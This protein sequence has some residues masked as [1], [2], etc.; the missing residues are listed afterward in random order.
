VSSATVNASPASTLLLGRAL[1]AP[2]N[3]GTRV[4]GR[5]LARATSSVRSVRLLSL[6]REQHLDGAATEDGLQL[7]H[8]PSRVGYGAAGD[9][10]GMRS[11]LGRLE[12][13]Q[14]RERISTAHLLSLP[15][16]L[17][18]ALHRRGIRV[19]AHL[20]AGADLHGVEKLRAGLGWRLFDYWI[21]A[22]SVSSSALIPTMLD[23]G[24]PLAKLE[25]L[26]AAIDTDAFQPGSRPAARARLGLDP[27][28][29]V[30]LYVGK[31]SPRR[32]PLE[33]V[34]Q[35]VRRL[36][37]ECTR[38]V[39]LYGFSPWDTHDGYAG[40]LR[41]D[42]GTLSA[43][44]LGALAAEGIVLARADLADAEKILWF[45]A[46]NVILF[47]FVAPESVEPPL[48]LLEAMAC[49]ATVLAT[50]VAN[51]S[52]LVEAGKN[53]LLYHDAEELVRKLALVSHPCR[54]RLDAMGAVARETVIKRHGFAVLSR[55]ASDLWTRIERPIDT[56]RQQCS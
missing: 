46:A 22:Y 6:T 40:S 38:P 30:I 14:Q 53:G 11:V 25:C 36:A 12:L 27:S 8:V 7:A 15:L 2:W 35:A 17:A 37:S 51:R 44:T 39:R 28:E 34:R 5:N 47:P 43:Q 13:L 41:T 50:P 33:E 23:R 29:L 20:R 52:R 42:G 10:A 19:V 45:R 55:A 49:G 16:A 18:P 3:E 21:D 31:V 26:P 1:H 48:T 9:Y 54:E 56:E 4:I 32:F 24:V